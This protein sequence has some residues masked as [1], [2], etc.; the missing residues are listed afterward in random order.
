MKESVRAGH[1]WNVGIME[2]WNT[3]C[4]GPGEM[5][6]LKDVADKNIR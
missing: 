2:N 6:Y 3:D 4:W 1:N 5:V